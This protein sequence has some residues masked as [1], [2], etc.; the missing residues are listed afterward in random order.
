LDYSIS[1]IGI[2]VKK[3]VIRV[4]LAVILL[5]ITAC[6]LATPLPVE[7]AQQQVHAAWLADRH[8]VWEID[9]PNT[10]VAGSVTVECW[11]AQDR[12]RYEVLE[13]PA[14]AL[15]GE[16][17]IYDGTTAWRYN[18][19]NPES[20]LQ[21]TEPV[22]SPVTD[23]FALIGGLLN[24]SP[25]QA[26]VDT[27]TVLFKPAQKLNLIF[28][29]GDTLTA[30]LDEPTGTILLR[31]EFSSGNNSGTLTAHQSEILVSPTDRLFT[32]P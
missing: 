27:D 1:Y 11:Q 21:P 19:L 12:Y 10:P 13:T 2:Q 17:L 23:V 29:N 30:W 16:V 32:A 6:S 31:V 26:T 5:P 4:Y 9:W 20:S 25:V 22:L 28:E 8:T 14:P 15:L 24:Q 18:R 3:Y 7:L